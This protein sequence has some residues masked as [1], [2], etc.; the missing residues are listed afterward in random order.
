RR[1]LGGCGGRSAVVP[2]SRAA[3][4][5]QWGEACCFFQSA[6]ALWGRPPIV[7]HAF[8]ISAGTSNG[9]NVQP[10]VSRAPLISSAPSGEPCDFSEPCLVGAPN[11]ILVLQAMSVGLSDV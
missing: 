10:S 4:W 6:C 7:R 11:P 2:R 8:M 1:A 9:G 3:R 5:P